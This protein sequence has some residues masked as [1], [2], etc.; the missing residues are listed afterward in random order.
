[1]R[2]P[3]L[4]LSFNPTIWRWQEGDNECSI[5]LSIRHIGNIDYFCNEPLGQFFSPTPHSILKYFRSEPECSFVPHAK[6]NGVSNW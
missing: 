5:A 6:V 4:V 1:M 2:S 3:H